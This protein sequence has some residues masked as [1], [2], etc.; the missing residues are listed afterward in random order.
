MNNTSHKKVFETSDKYQQM[1]INYSKPFFYVFLI[2]GFNMRSPTSFEVVNSTSKLLSLCKNVA[3]ILFCI[4]RAIIR[5]LIA[6]FTICCLDWIYNMIKICD[7]EK[8]IRFVSLSNAILGSVVTYIYVIYKQ[9]SIFILF[10]NVLFTFGSKARILLDTNVGS[11][12]KSKIRVVSIAFLFHMMLTCF[13][14]F[15]IA[16]TYIHSN[17]RSNPSFTCE[18]YSGFLIIFGCEWLEKLVAATVFFCMAFFVPSTIMAM[19]IFTFFIF[20]INCHLDIFTSRYT[21]IGEISKLHLHHYVADVIKIHKEFCKIISKVNCNF[22]F[23]IFIW[24][25]MHI[26]EVIC[27]VRV[28][29]DD[30]SKNHNTTAVLLIGLNINFLKLCLLTSSV[31]SKVSYFSLHYNMLFS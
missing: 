24:F 20:L 4:Y 19:N 10:Q 2:F 29:T 7:I 31:N 21:N 17:R 30:V 25:V 28:N 5:L 3:R 14:C 18:V 1:L 8:C 9:D 15:G 13:I 11:Q 22:S 16:V 23:L 12:M 27:L 26:F 6:T